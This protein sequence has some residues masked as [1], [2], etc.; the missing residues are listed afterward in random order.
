MKTGMANDKVLGIDIG[1]SAIKIAQVNVGKDRHFVEAYTSVPLPF[2]TV[3]DGRIADGKHAIVV[4]AIKAAMDGGMFS[5]KDAVVGLNSSSAVFFRQTSIPRMSDETL[6]KSIVNIVESE[7]AGFDMSEMHVDYS[8]LGN[9]TRGSKLRVML[10]LV[11]DQYAEAL[12]KAVEDAG[13]NVVGADLSALATLRGT[14]INHRT[15]ETSVIV[16]IGAEI[17]SVLMHCGGV[18]SALF[19][20]PTGAG[21]DASKAIADVAGGDP[22]SEDLEAFKTANNRFDREVAEA[23]TEYGQIVADKLTKYFEAFARE[24]PD[25]PAIRSITL[26]GGGSFLQGLARVIQNNFD[27]NIHYGKPEPMFDGDLS[28][29]VLHLTAIGLA[30]GAQE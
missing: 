29:A 26:V 28:H 5:T 20:D 17:T 9:E 27:L 10:Y 4:N 22:E 7:N 30:T 21:H 24:N 19:I 1:S 15:D 18:P 2:E 8:V 25:A 6:K 14:E 16:G 3:V 12:C 23:I 11:Q 13:L